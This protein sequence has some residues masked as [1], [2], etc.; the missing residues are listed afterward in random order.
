MCYHRHEGGSIQNWATWAK[1]LKEFSQ[2]LLVCYS[3]FNPL[4]YCGDLVYRSTVKRLINCCCRKQLSG[5]SKD[6]L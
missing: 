6:T 2:V 1:V 4:A 5:R 3:A